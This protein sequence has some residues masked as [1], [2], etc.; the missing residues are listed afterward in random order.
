[1][2]SISYTYEG[3]TYEAEYDFLDDDNIVVYL[4]D[5]RKETWLRGLDPRQAAMRHLQIY[6]HAQHKKQDQG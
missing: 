1:M 6:A 2:Y 4:P 3:A 5:G